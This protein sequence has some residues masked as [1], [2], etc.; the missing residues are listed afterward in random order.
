MVIASGDE[1]AP[2]SGI[3]AVDEDLI[4]NAVRL[5]GV[6]YLYEPKW[7]KP[8]IKRPPAY[9]LLASYFSQ[10]CGA[11]DV[12]VEGFEIAGLGQIGAGACR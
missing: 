11:R 5:T 12:G 7:C 4:V 9:T 2:G 3:C 1:Q 8:A 10:C 6:R